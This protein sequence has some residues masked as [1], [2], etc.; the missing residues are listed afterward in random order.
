MPAQ[1]RLNLERAPDYARSAFVVSSSNAQAVATLDSWPDWRG[2]ALALVGPPGSGKTHLADVWAERLGASR[3][4]LMPDPSRPLLIE[5]AERSLDAAVNRA[6]GRV[7]DALHRRN[8]LVLFRSEKLIGEAA[9]Q[10]NPVVVAVSCSQEDVAIERRQDGSHV[11]SIT[12]DGGVSAD[13]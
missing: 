3:W 8:A 11:A 5:D 13:R 10:S 4:P 7:T 9:A 1:L 12:V 6:A 2:G